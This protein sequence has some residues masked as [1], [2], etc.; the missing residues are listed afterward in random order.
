MFSMFQSVQSIN[1]IC[2][3]TLKDPCESAGEKFMEGVI[4]CS[5]DGVTG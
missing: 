1:V 3:Y 2:I 5:F 4:V